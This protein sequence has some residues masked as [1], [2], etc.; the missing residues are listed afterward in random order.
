MPPAAI[1]DRALIQICLSMENLE[2]RAR[3]IRAIVTATKELNV[4]RLFLLTCDEAEQRFRQDGYE[5]IAVPAWKILLT[6]A[7]WS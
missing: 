3:E 1:A 5:I 2:T 4:K 6:A 7:I